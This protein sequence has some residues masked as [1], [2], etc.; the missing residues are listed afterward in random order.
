MATTKRAPLVVAVVVGVALIAV[1]K[2]I[3][4]GGADKT[5]CT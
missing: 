3:S 5:P 2:S 4:G 1:V